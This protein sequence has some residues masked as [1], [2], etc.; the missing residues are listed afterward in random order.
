VNE[1]RA[2]L[3][4]TKRLL[5][6]VDCVLACADPKSWD[7]RQ[8]KH[9]LQWAVCRFGLCDIDL[10][11]FSL[12]GA[13]LMQLQYSEFAK[14]IPN[15]SDNTFWTHLELLKKYRFVCKSVW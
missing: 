15:D 10:D 13:Q 14:Y 8:T 12:N 11:S 1:F 5:T 2:R 4:I 3:L 7:C 9:W 6:N